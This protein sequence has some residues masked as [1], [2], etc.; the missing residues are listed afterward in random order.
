MGRHLFAT[1]LLLT[2]TSA[3]TLV[4]SPR[5]GAEVDS[6]ERLRYRLF[7]SINNFICA[8]VIQTADSHY[9]AQ[10]TT[11]ERS[12][13]LRLTRTQVERIAF[14]INNDSAIAAQ[15]A[16]DQ[17]SAAALERFWAELESSEAAESGTGAV[18]RKPVPNRPSVENRVFWTNRGIWMGATAGNAAAAQFAIRQVGWEQPT[19]CLPAIAVYHVNHPLFWTTTT[20]ATLLG[21]TLGYIHGASLDRGQIGDTMPPK[22]G[23]GTFV[24]TLV[25]VVLGSQAT[26]LIWWWGVTQFGYRYPLYSKIDNDPHGLTVIPAFIAGIGVMVDLTYL[27]YKVGQAFDRR[28]AAAAAK[29]K[30]R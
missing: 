15:V 24:G 9:C 28:S 30:P 13:S 19:E 26:R 22:S 14:I 21:G 11:A 18:A 29:A 5:V 20:G 16:D 27:G 2:V 7:P 6:V 8:S 10:V 25:G 4:I 17:F 12:Y 23:I 1:A 3:G